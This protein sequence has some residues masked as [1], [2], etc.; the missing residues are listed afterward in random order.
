MAL[1]YFRDAAELGDSNG[2]V[3]LGYM[4][5]KVCLP[6]SQSLPLFLSLS[7]SLSLSE[8]LSHFYLSIAVPLS[9][10]ELSRFQGRGVPQNNATALKYFQKAARMGNAAAHVHIGNMYLN[11]QGIPKDMHKALEHFHQ[12][13]TQVPS[14]LSPVVGRSLLLCVPMRSLSLSL[15]LSVDC[16]NAARNGLRSLFHRRRDWQKATLCWRTCTRT[17]G[18]PSRT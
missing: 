14:S 18:E 4:Y 11:G 10:L 3:M 12:A 7:L 16:I 1:R 15:F 2:I 13:S 5:L 8:Y 17:D 6:P 9:C